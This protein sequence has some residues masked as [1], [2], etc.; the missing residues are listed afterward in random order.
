MTVVTMQLMTTSLFLFSVPSG[1]NIFTPILQ[2]G[3]LRLI[4]TNPSQCLFENSLGPL[5][6]LRY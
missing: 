2:M 4:F 3:K 5:R 1:R 6:L